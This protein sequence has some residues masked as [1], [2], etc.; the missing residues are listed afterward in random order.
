MQESLARARLPSDDA[1]MW[2]DQWRDRVVRWME[3][4]HQER[5]E[6]IP[7]PEAIDEAVDYYQG[8]HQGKAHDPIAFRKLLRRRGLPDWVN[9]YP[10]GPERA[11]LHEEGFLWADVQVLVED[12]MS[13][14]SRPSL[15][16]EE[17]DLLKVHHAQICWMMILQETG[18]SWPRSLSS[19]HPD[20]LVAITLE[21][22]L[23]PHLGMWGLDPGQW[24]TPDL[25]G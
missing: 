1:S 11:A 22:M 2:H 5:S 16:Q 17:G 25:L 15:P 8:I 14:A 24:K 6:G 12:L 20:N 9:P 21:A 10:L 19:I 7:S 4:R 18:G 3:H 13:R 23:N